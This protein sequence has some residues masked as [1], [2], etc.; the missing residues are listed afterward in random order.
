MVPNTYTVNTASGQLEEGGGEGE[1][2][3]RRGGG[4]GDTLTRG[5]E[6]WGFD[7]DYSTGLSTPAHTPN[8][9]T[10]TPQHISRSAA[11]L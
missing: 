3:G 4:G 9:A 2:E 5:Y 8:T 7:T 6:E 11:P 1:G 10:H